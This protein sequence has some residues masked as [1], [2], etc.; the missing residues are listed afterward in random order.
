MAWHELLSVAKGYLQS[1]NLYLQVG[2]VQSW[3]KI[4]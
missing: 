1:K 2:F 3:V 4:T